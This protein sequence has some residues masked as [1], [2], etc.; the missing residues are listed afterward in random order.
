MERVPMTIYGEAKLSAELRQLIK[1]ERP[2]I[3]AAIE[4]ALGHGDLKENAEYHSAKEKQG[5]IE[6]RIRELESKLSRVEI[7][8]PTKLK[9]DRVVMGATLTLVDVDTDAE[10]V[11]SLVGPDEADIKKGLVSV[12]SPIGKALIGKQEGD[13]AIVQAPAGKRIYEIEAIK[14]QPIDV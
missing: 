12:T 7:I 6:G 5:F 8:D 14:Y 10:V 11:Y 9:T 4:E 1:I 13:E 3:S 2:A